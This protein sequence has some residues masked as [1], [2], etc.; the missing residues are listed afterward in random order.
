MTFE[1]ALQEI[2]IEATTSRDVA[3]RIVARLLKLRLA[4]EDPVAL[5]RL[6]VAWALAREQLPPPRTFLEP[7]P[8]P[9]GG[10]TPFPLVRQH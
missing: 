7:P 10:Q 8:L 5:R 4:A 1:E 3:L 6:R 9:R 2:G